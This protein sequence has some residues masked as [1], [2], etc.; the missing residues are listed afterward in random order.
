MTSLARSSRIPSR[1]AS[2]PSAKFA[3][4]CPTCGSAFIPDSLFC[5]KCGERRP[6]FENEP[7]DTSLDLRR[8]RVSE[9]ADASL[10]LRRPRNQSLREHG[11]REPR[12]SPRAERN[13]SLRYGDTSFSTEALRR[14]E[15]QLSDT[16]SEL[17]AARA[18]AR[19][20]T[21]EASK[22]DASIKGLREQASMWEQEALG[23]RGRIAA[24]EAEA[25]RERGALEGEASR[26]R[27]AR[28]DARHQ[29]ESMQADCNE[30][31][32]RKHGELE[33]ALAQIDRLQKEKDEL[34]EQERK[35]RQTIADVEEAK[36][37]DAKVHAQEMELGKQRYE[38]AEARNRELE[39]EVSH[40]REVQE[41][42]KA[43]LKA[44]SESH[45]A[46]L[47]AVSESH[48][49][50]LKAVSDSHERRN[51][52]LTAVI[53]EKTQALEEQ[54]RQARESLA[55]QEQRI[56]QRAER[57]LSDER[58]AD[59]LKLEAQMDV[60]KAQK[61]SFEEAEANWRTRV[62][63]EVDSARRQEAARVRDELDSAR[64]KEAAQET[65]HRSSRV[66]S[67]WADFPDSPLTSAPLQAS[68]RTSS[69]SCRACGAEFLF[70]SIFCANC[71]AKRPSRD[72][73]RQPD[74]SPSTLTRSPMRQPDQSPSTRTRSPRSPSNLWSSLKSPELREAA[75]RRVSFLEE[76]LTQTIER[77]QDALKSAA[78]EGEAW[79]NCREKLEERLECMSREKSREL[80]FAGEERASALLSQSR[81]KQH[82]TAAQRATYEL[83]EVQENLHEVR[84]HQATFAES[85]RKQGTDLEARL[86]RTE[87]ERDRLIEATN[88]LRADL[89]AL[90]RKGDANGSTDLSWQ[91]AD[92][93]SLSSNNNRRERSSS[94][95]QDVRGSEAVRALQQR[96][97]AVKNT[98]SSVVRSR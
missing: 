36:K 87:R 27:R 3:Q 54:E 17:V 94:V 59:A 93:R 30:R 67:H 6:S 98:T 7:A 51:S 16:R 76:E 13:R 34:V 14:K 53:T 22:N 18:E 50:K 5:R 56:H 44:L 28:D 79:Q 52:K 75:T 78:R 86:E 57:W 41:A 23:L 81:S 1:S 71:G 60:A 31:L 45:E 43:K 63:E 92:L 8:S 40:L 9:P 72:D 2:L 4:I 97:S 11:D 29:A 21:E 85:W 39:Q 33:D 24:A 65:T 15:K 66:D 58:H 96:Y 91:E 90:G 95:G 77:E 46:K 70:D 26:L 10:E 12:S 55:A 48:E 61:E 84:S 64:R 37:R 89:R 80:S 47:K 32:A 68:P 74:R 38:A 35:L 73:L 20:A 82:E 49:A 42:A 88:E 19:R 25:H 83:R 69:G 62:K